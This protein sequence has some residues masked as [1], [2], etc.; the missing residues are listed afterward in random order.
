MENR[1]PGSDRDDQNPIFYSMAETKTLMQ[2]L[3]F[4]NWELNMPWT[5]LHQEN[6]MQDRDGN[7]KI[8]DI[9]LYGS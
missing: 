3:E 4:L 9:G 5:D 8:I 2:T 7:L 1:F 6:L